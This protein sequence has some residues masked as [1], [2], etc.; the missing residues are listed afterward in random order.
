MRRA[1]KWIGVGAVGIVVV[2]AV[3]AAGF[4]LYAQSVLFRTYEIEPV[5][6]ELP[7]DPASLEHGRHLALAVAKC[8][9]CHD[10]DM[11]GKVIWDNPLGRFTAP[12][13]TPGRGG[14]GGELT[15]DDYVRAIRHGVGR[16]R[17]PLFYMSA[18]YFYEFSDQDLAAMIAWLRSLPPVDREL[19][20]FELRLRS[21]TDWMRGNFPD[22][23]HTHLV[24]H[25]APHPGAPAPG[26]T[27][28][29]GRY[30]VYAASCRAC[31]GDE[32]AGH[33][34]FA[35]S[36]GAPPLTAGSRSSTWT[37]EEFIRAMRTGETP[38]GGRISPEYMNLEYTALLTD[39]ELTAMWLFLRSLPA[40]AVV[41]ER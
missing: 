25:D 38:G 29:Y 27:P 7:T 39:E 28:E 1:L 4:Y 31:H 10:H 17:Q 32:L 37:V 21:R 20:P 41:A 35:Y 19:P 5:A 40:P 11:G 12:N 16:D 34:N 3:V 36:R 30:L 14:V 2:L 33:P 6:L 24:D 13:L 26:A 22:L 18:V 9:L 15:T 23:V 8:A